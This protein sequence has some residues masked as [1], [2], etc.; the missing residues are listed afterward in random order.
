MTTKP[1]YN[2]NYINTTLLFPPRPPVPPDAVATAAPE[3]PPVPPGCRDL[4]MAVW[5]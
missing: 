2:H 3:P 5:V 4:L 1:T